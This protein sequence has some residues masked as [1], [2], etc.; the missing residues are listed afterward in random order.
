MAFS[1]LLAPETLA[2]IS[3]YQLLAHHIAEGFISGMHRSLR[4]GFGSEFLQYRDYTPGDDLKYLDWKAYARSDRYYAKVF[5]EETNFQCHIIIDCSESMGYQGSGA[6]CSKLDYARMLAAGLAYLANC[7][8]DAI[9]LYAY[10]DECLAHLP[11]RQNSTHLNNLLKQLVN[12]KAAGT[13]DHNRHLNLLGG[14]LRRRGMI[15]FLSDFLSEGDHLTP[16]L[17]KLQFTRHD[18]LLMQILSPDERDLLF[19]GTHRFIEAESDRQITTTP[20]ECRADY[21]QQLQAWQKTLQTEAL[22]ANMVF[23]SFYTDQNL[24]GA[25]TAYL[26]RREALK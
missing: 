18:A 24:G 16:L 5:Q 2:H 17:R 3:N 14:S 4:H 19:S 20:D 10:H 15:I 26:N 23:D 21:L 11:A 7:Q 9:G 8:G 25:L 22:Q 1:E 13:A 6:A 12:L